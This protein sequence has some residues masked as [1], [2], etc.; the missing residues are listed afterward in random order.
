MHVFGEPVGRQIVAGAGFLGLA[1]EQRAGRRELI[2]QPEIV[3]E[4]GDSSS[5]VAARGAPTISSGNVG[6]L[7]KSIASAVAQPRPPPLSAVTM[8]LVAT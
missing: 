2:A 8:S 4:T 7:E 5:D 3:E 6:S 1:V